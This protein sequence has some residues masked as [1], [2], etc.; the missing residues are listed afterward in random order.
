M[1]ASSFMSASAS[2]ID[3]SIEAVE[4]YKCCLASSSLTKAASPAASVAFFISA[5]LVVEAIV[6]TVSL[7]KR[8]ALEEFII[9]PSEF[10]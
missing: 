8:T 3:V 5:S 1:A 2:V 9:S 6:N 4:S 10:F 7:S